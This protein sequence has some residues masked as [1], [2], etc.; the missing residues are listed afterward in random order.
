MKSLPQRLLNLSQ[1]MQHDTAKTEKL[2]KL[3]HTPSVH[4]A[5]TV[6]YQCLCCVPNTDAVAKRIKY[7][8][9]LNR[10]LSELAHLAL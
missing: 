6:R 9:R 5:L 1:T 2:S 4:G 3:R 7:S 10:K 8:Q